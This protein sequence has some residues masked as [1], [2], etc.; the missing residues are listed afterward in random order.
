VLRLLSEGINSGRLIDEILLLDG[1][2]RKRKHDIP[3]FCDLS[4]VAFAWKKTENAIAMTESG[5]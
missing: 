3:Q 4:R 2:T 5:D 1:A